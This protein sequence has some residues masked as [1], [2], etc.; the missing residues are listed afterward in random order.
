MAVDD[1]RTA[2]WQRAGKKRRKRPKP[3][4]PLANKGKRTG[5]T[6]RSPAEVAAYLARIGPRKEVSADG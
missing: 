4:S 3:I 5:R 2:N 6:D 1:L